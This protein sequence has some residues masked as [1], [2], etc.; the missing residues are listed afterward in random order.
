MFEFPYIKGSIA[1][2]AEN[3]RKYH[4]DD[5]ATFH[6]HRLVFRVLFEKGTGVGVLMNSAPI[7]TS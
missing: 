1:E 7:S 4:T 5:D 2:A 6:N 3:S